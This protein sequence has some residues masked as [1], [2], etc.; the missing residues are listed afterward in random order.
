LGWFHKK[1]K[2]KKKTKRRGQERGR[3]G[4]KGVWW[5]L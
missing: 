2:K 3:G 4:Y 5:L 1:K